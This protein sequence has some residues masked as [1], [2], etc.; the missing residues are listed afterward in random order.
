[1]VDQPEYS[2]P[3]EPPA[4]PPSEPQPAVG[5]PDDHRLAYP[6]GAVHWGW[7]VGTMVICVGM[8]VVPWYLLNDGKNR[9]FLAYTFQSTPMG[10]GL[11]GG[12]ASCLALVYS[13][14]YAHRIVRR[15]YR[16]RHQ[17]VRDQP[18]IFYVRSMLLGM[19][20]TI[21]TLTTFVCCCVPTSIPFVQYSAGGGMSGD[22]R[23]PTAFSV[24]VALAVGV[25]IIRQLLPREDLRS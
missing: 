14:L 23:L 10:L 11:L 9:R 16:R 17:K 2:N 13:L 22:T 6:L 4:E 20:L 5:E 25:F 19:L 8:I 12:M 24:L 1:M 18:F 21:S 3:Y 7:L 15:N